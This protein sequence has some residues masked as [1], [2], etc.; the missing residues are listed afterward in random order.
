MSWTTKQTKD[1]SLH[2]QYGDLQEEGRGT[3]THCLS[4]AHVQCI[5][6]RGEGA[7]KTAPPKPTPSLNVLCFATHGR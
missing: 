6:L 7:L 5:H 4:R 3:G 1:A 2:V